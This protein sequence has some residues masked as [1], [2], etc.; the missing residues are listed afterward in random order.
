MEMDRARRAQA[1]FTA[2]LDWPKTERQLRVTEACAGDE[3][4]ASRVWRLLAASD[5]DTDFLESPALSGRL[6]G[7]A[8]MPDAVGDYLVVGVLGTGGMATV[9]E[10]V[11]ENPNRSVALKV[12]R[13]GL[14][15]TDALLRFRL[16][17]ETLARLHHPGIAQ[18]YEAGSAMLGHDSPSPFF[19]MELV[20]DA[21]PHTEY[22]RRHSLSLRQRLE[23]FATICEAVLHGHQ[24]GIIH[25]D[26][27]PAN[28]L[29]GADGRA[30]VI[31][32]GIARATERAPGGASTLTHYS[33]ARKLIGTLNY[34][35]P[36]QCLRP[37]SID[38]RADVYALGVMLYELVT[39]RLPHDLTTCSIPEAV[40]II[41]HD[42]P[43][44]ASAHCKDAAGDL[45]AIIAKAMSKEPDHRY[46]GAG[47]LAADVRSWLDHLPIE[48]RPASAADHLRKF[49]RRNRWLAASIAALAL[50]LIAGAT[51]ATWFAYRA[52]V[53]RDEALQRQHE[54]AVASEFQE[55][56][57]RDINVAAMGDRLRESFKESIQRAAD[58]DADNP[59]TADSI[60]LVNR[61]ADRV[62]F[63][64]LAVRSLRETILKRYAVEIDAR[65]AEQPLLRARLQQQLAS[66]LNSLGLHADAEPLLRSALET[67]RTMLGEDH[68]DTLQ[69]L[70]SLG[71]LL[72]TLGRFDE[73]LP[74]L[75]DVYARR[76]RVFGADHVATLRAGSSLAGLYRVRGD[77]AEAERIW[78]DVLAEQRRALGDDDPD[79]LR[80]LNNIGVVFASQ[81]KFKEAEA[82]WRELLERRRRILGEHHPEFLSSLGN[83]GA[84]LQAQGRLSEARPM[85][86]QALA[87]DRYRLG[88]LHANTLVSM[89]QLASLLQDSGELAQAESLWK[90]CLNGRVATLGAESPAALRTQSALAVVLHLRGDN[91]TA[92]R[93]L[94]SALE[95]QTRLLGERHP[96]T[97][98]SQKR[99]REI[100]GPLAKPPSVIP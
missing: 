89:A 10:A 80:T 76:G 56:L 14:T 95:N 37:E 44:R 53:A 3:I 21:L 28:V 99:L 49:V 9:Y 32:F 15:H 63:T 22:A 42:D 55:S 88:D 41:T 60:A 83:L 74:I 12:M 85:L 93:L 24:H 87:A 7:G 81:N 62:N 11:Q 27:K 59:E 2:A 97:V 36:E 29:V 38:I 1:I 92:L 91:E 82:Y 50:S 100:E 6:P 58:T 20:K 90:E 72:T 69:T 35:S 78:S 98:D 39:D 5:R 45:D 94:K 46:A 65:F 84:L 40:R 51:V 68:E 61:I 25:R 57:L 31:D 4:L 18:I 34:M 30:K 13:A 8:P 70:N 19:A 52:G 33:D 47:A 73:A 17:T 16:E 77:L 67:R 48:A 23:M 86:E 79:T 26:L 43:P 66:T 64:S 71:S 54:L 75:K 96:D